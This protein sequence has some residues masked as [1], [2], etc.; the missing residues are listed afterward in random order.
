MLWKSIPKKID[1][2]KNNFTQTSLFRIVGTATL[3]CIVTGCVGNLE[4]VHVDMKDYSAEY[5]HPEKSNFQDD[6]GRFCKGGWL[7]AD[8]R[9][10]AIHRGEIKEIY[11][12]GKINESAL[13]TEFGEIVA[14]IKLGRTSDDERIMVVL[15]GLG[16]HDVF[17][18]SRV[19]RIAREK[20]IGMIVRLN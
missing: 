20:N 17:V 10:Q 6:C 9:E 14:G 1:M 18:A 11:A 4:T 5:V 19:Y 2:K 16:A 13:F 3:L 8:C 12:A 15:V 7:F